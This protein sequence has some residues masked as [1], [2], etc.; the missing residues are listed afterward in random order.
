MSEDQVTVQVFVG[1][2]VKRTDF[3]LPKGTEIRCEGKGFWSRGS[4]QG[5]T[6]ENPLHEYCPQCGGK[7]VEKA[8]FVESKG[9]VK[10]AESRNMTPTAIWAGMTRTGTASTWDRVG[11][12]SVRYLGDGGLSHM[13][14]FKDFDI[15]G[16]MMVSESLDHRLKGGNYRSVLTE[17][18][19]LGFLGQVSEEVEKVAALILPE[20]RLDIRV[21]TTVQGNS[22]GLMISE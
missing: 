22:N 6:R 18:L 19:R 16:V 7:F 20:D 9:L 17:G 4:G 2:R 12:H 10:Y 1:V 13:D 5:H 15:F 11:I 8:I 21:Y 3:W 14:E